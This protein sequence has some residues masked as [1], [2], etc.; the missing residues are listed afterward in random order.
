[1]EISGGGGGS[2][3]TITEQDGSPSGV[4]TLLKVTNGTLTDNGGGSFS[5]ITG[6]GGGSGISS[7]NADT[8]SA[9]T[10]TVGTS[11]TDF[12]ISDNGTGTHTFNLPTASATNRGA[13]SSADWTTFNNKGSGTVTAVS[14]VSANGFTG[15]SSGGATPAL[16]LTTSITGV[17]KGNGTA[18]SAASDGTDYLSPTTGITVSQSSGQTLG[19][20]TNRLT[21]LWATDIT[22]TNAIS[23]SVTGNAGTATALQNARTIGGVSFDGTANITVASAT[24]GFA[25]SGGNLTTSA[26]NI[27]TDTTTGTKIGTAT[28]QKLGFFNSTPIVQ[29]TGDVVTALQNLGL[30]ASLTVAATTIASRTLW[31]QTY[32]GSANV[33][34]SLTSVGNITGGASSMTILAGTGA[35]RTLTLQTTDS[36]SSA[37]TVLTLDAA[38]LATFAGNLTVGTSNSITTGTIELGATSDTTIARASAGVASI[39]GNN[40]VVNTSSPTLGTITTTGNIE[41][42]NASDTTLSRSAAGVLSVEGVDV[43]TISASQTLTNKTLTSPTIQTTPVYASGTSLILT[44][45]TSDDT[46][47]GEITNAFNSGYTSSAIGDLVYLDSSSTWQKADADASATTYQGMLGIALEVKT[48]GNALKVLLRGFAYCSTAFPTF[49]VGGIVYM[50]ATA[51]AVTQTA[52]TTT[53]SATRILGYAVHA[54]KMWFNPSNDYVTHT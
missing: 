16:T 21:K 11:G 48:S 39:E 53:D 7:I 49:T 31:G 52:P 37:Q 44:V 18:I 50:S 34:G 9:Q 40:I 3:V 42:G 22:V 4:L 27:V 33:T 43:A 15:S 32:D 20:T 24:G 29:P 5:L 12:A 25:V 30:G 19:T 28:T 1:M 10:L 13:L 41:L 47:T 23:G 2:S 26:I 38:K 51:G 17:L 45:P 46:A 54:D 8:T 35:S 6:G 14:V 36:G